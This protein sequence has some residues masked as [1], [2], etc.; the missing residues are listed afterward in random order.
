MRSKFWLWIVLPLSILSIGEFFLSWYVSLAH[1]LVLFVIVVLMRAGVLEFWKRVWKLFWLTFPVLVFSLQTKKTGLYL[2]WF[3]LDPVIDYSVLLLRLVN[4]SL[5][6]WLVQKSWYFSLD[7][8]GSW[9]WARVF[10]KA[11]GLVLDMW[12]DILRW[13]RERFGLREWIER[14]YT[15]EVARSQVSSKNIDNVREDE[16]RRLK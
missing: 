7:R 12:E 10:W 5:S 9:Y 1:F 15:E 3:Y 2:G 6:F 11:F 8:I 13:P 16:T 14:R 4:F